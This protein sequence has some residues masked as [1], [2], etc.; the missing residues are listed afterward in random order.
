MSVFTSA[1][2][3]SYYG[4]PDDGKNL[5]KKVVLI[6]GIQGACFSKEISNLV[7]ND[8]VEDEAIIHVPMRTRYGERKFTIQGK[9]YEIWKNYLEIRKIVVLSEH[10]FLRMS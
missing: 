6:F 8:V 2:I 5:V 7:L 1:E 9:C 3:E 10:F 4:L